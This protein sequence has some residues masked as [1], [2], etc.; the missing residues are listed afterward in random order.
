MHIGDG[1][2]GPPCT[3]DSADHP[4]YNITL[5]GARMISLNR[6]GDL[7]P[8]VTDPALYAFSFSLYDLQQIAVS[9]LRFMA[10]IDE[11]EKRTVQSQLDDVQAS[12]RSQQSEA[13][14]VRER[15]NHLCI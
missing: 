14:Q 7:P 10:K 13:A 11:N 1:Y 4:H 2:G 6:D 12:L 15:A 5:D 9:T 3:Q 8:N